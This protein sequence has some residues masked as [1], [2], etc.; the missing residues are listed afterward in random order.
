MCC[1]MIEWRN[2]MVNMSLSSNNCLFLEYVYR[3]DLPTK[4]GLNNSIQL[5]DKLWMSPKHYVYHRKTR[6]V[7]FTYVIQIIQIIVVIIFKE[8]FP[9]KH[10]RSYSRASPGRCP[11]FRQNVLVFLGVSLG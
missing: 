11:G 4:R 6:K 3:M 5:T 2:R 10:G 8:Q 7:F 9:H 1:L